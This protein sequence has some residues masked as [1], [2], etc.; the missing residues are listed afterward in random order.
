MMRR[1]Y[2][3]LPSSQF[4]FGF[5]LNTGSSNPI[6]ALITRTVFDNRCI[7]PSHTIPEVQLTPTWDQWAYLTGRVQGLHVLL[8]YNYR[9]FLLG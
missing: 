7:K 2:L 4:G 3:N 1:Q 5:W 9:S 8:G 6:L